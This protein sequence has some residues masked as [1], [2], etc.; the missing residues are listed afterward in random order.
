[1]KA[2]QFMSDI[3]YFLT[4]DTIAWKKV[5]QSAWKTFD[6]RFRNILARLQNHKRLLERQADL[7]TIE[8]LRAQRLRTEEMFQQLED[9]ELKRRHTAVRDKLRP[10]NSSLDQEHTTGKRSDYPDT[11]QWFLQ[12]DKFEKW[13]SF[14]NVDEPVLWLNGIPGAGMAAFKL[15]HDIV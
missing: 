11:G 3:R 2:I 10:A 5:F 1:M 14:S 12:S 8:D 9:S 4:E 13:K 6:T 7:T 15:T